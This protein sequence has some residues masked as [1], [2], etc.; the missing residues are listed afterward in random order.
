VLRHA[1][2]AAESGR[3]GPVV[4]AIPEDVLDDVAA[5]DDLPRY[6]VPRP[7]PAAHDVER[8]HALL[9]RAQRPLVLAG[10][11]GWD[12]ADYDAL[13]GFAERH[14]VPVATT[15]RRQALFDNDHPLY[16]GTAGIAVDP[17]LAARVRDADVIL[18]LGTRLDE[19]TTGGYT[20]IE[21]LPRQRLV[22]V[23]PGAEELGRVF[24]AELAIESTAG[25]FL[26]AFSALPALDACAWNAWA[27]AAH[28]DYQRREQAPVRPDGLDMTAVM[29]TLRATLPPDAIVTN[30]AGNYTAWPQ[31]FYRYRR[32]GT[33]VAPVS[34]AMG[35]GL[36]AAIA[37]QLVHPDR[38]VVAF[39]GDGCFQM[40]GHELGTARQYDLPI[41]TIIVENGMHGTIRM[42]QERRFPGRPIGT[43]ILNPDFVAYA[44]S[45]GAHAERIASA[46]DFSAALQRALN[47]RT[48]TVLVLAC[49]TP[50][51]APPAA[52][53]SEAPRPVSASAAPSPVISSAAPSPVISSAAP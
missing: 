26:A 17:A 34:G 32:R 24:A 8:A 43:D 46:A 20:L 15:F 18:A 48:T 7:V 33:Q 25:A 35:Y 42:H 52:V 27:A 49:T 38:I 5:V 28:A 29:A 13:R 31:R 6:D 51:A 41:L 19:V 45:F 10:G 39:A 11:G 3:P 16:A 50:S 30:G 1:F 53:A 9:A 4:I 14:G 23:Y 47:A 36:P 2:A 40:S 21:P 22:H 37:A 12:D 44:R